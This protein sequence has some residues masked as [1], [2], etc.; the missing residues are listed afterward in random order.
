MPN[1]S[2][3]MSKALN[4]IMLRVSSLGIVDYYICNLVKEFKEN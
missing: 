4:N 1:A 3:K 2:N